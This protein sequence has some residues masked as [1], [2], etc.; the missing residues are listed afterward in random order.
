MFCRTLVYQQ[1]GEYKPFL[2]A[3]L[4]W[5]NRVFQ[6]I[7]CII[8]SKQVPLASLSIFQ[9]QLA[10]SCTLIKLYCMVSLRTIN[11]SILLQNQAIHQ[12]IMNPGF[13]VLSLVI[14][15]ELFQMLLHFGISTDMANTRV[16][17]PHS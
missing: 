14:R 4:F 16:K 2:K 3:L 10:Q 8:F 9:L 5:E 11:N 6:T 7:E 12:P 15:Q 1:F 13:T 17:E